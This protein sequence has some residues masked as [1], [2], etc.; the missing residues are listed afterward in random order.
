MILKVARLGHPVLRRKARRVSPRQVGS[1][2]VQ[3]LIRDMV[4]TMR[5]YDG[6][7]IAAPQVHLALQIAA[8]GV[9]HNPR[10]PKA[11]RIPL[12][13]LINPRVRPASRRQ[14]KDWE[15]CLSVEG[16]RG[17]VPRW[18]SVEVEA[19]N[20]QGKPVRFR[21]SGFFA[22]VIQHE[23]DHLQGKVFLDRMTDLSTLTHLTEY[24]RYWAKG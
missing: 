17:R 1:P 13:L 23:W 18:H 10:Y 22:R 6:V 20:A 14:V 19:Y 24:A 11:R 3:A 12:T 9:D 15:G 5:E 16:L 2:G 7:G 8:I 21:A 4:E